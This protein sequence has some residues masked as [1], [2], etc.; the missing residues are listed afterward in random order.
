ME[1]PQLVSML[2]FASW[3]NLQQRRHSVRIASSLEIWIIC[4]W[5]AVSARWLLSMNEHSHNHNSKFN[6]AMR[7]E[8]R[9]NEWIWDS[10]FYGS[11][12]AE[13]TNNNNN[14]KI[15][16]N[17]ALN[18]IFYLYYMYSYVKRVS[19]TRTN[20]FYS[21]H[22]RNAAASMII[23]ICVRTHEMLYILHKPR[24]SCHS[25]PFDSTLWLFCNS[26]F[27]DFLFSFSHTSTD[28]L[29]QQQQQLK[30]ATHTTKPYQI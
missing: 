23:Y 15:Y 20:V 26:G 18:N 2:H 8:E 14:I 21:Y 16:N 17:R 28:V 22:R 7:C 29:Q 4:I 6:C 10:E 27:S 5:M 30:P 11:G 3:W 1:W 13:P 25:L 9:K 12:E 24:F 19:K